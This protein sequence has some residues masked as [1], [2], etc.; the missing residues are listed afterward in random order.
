MQETNQTYV[1]KIH[2]KDPVPPLSDIEGFA[3][4]YVDKMFTRGSRRVPYD[5]SGIWFTFDNSD[6]LKTI[7]RSDYLGVEDYTPIKEKINQFFTETDLPGWVDDVEF[8]IMSYDEL[9]DQTERSASLVWKNHIPDELEVLSVDE[10]HSILLVTD[11][12]QEFQVS[13]RQYKVHL[14]KYTG[15]EM[16]ISPGDLIQT[17]NIS[18]SAPVSS[19]PLQLS[20]PE[21]E[22]A[23]A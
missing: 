10:E 11:G 1:M 21:E 14:E 15:E 8:T 3:A 23:V 13:S 20:V 5:L 17:E 16:D 4:K 18:R 22:K 12:N 19:G 2:T 9:T 6:E 7:K